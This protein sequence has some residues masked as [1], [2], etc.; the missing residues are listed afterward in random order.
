VGWLRDLVLSSPNRVGGFDHLA[1]LCLASAD[2]P[3]NVRLGHRSLGAILGKLDRDESLDWLANRPGVQAAIAGALG[4]ERAVVQDAT[5]GGRLG[6]PNRLVALDA[7]PFARGLDLLE[8]D[9]FPG[10]PPEVF[11]SGGY[12]RLVW[13]CPSGGGRSLVGRWLRARGLATI[14]RR[15]NLKVGGPSSERRPLFLEL[16]SAEGLELSKLNPGICVTVPEDGDGGRIAERLAAEAEARAGSGAG[17]VRIVRSVPIDSLLRPLVEWAR[18]RLSSA[19]TW[20]T[21]AMVSA[22]EGAVSRGVARS[23]GD[24]LGLVGLAD[25]VGLGVFTGRSLSRLGAEWIRRRAS[26]RLERD[27]PITA[28][29]KNHGYEALV[30][31]VRRIATEDDDAISD[32]RTL[33][34]WARLL[35][36]DMKRGADLEWLKTALTRAEPS[37]RA[38]D[39]ERITAELP[40]EAF[41]ILRA[42]EALGVL[43]RTEDGASALRPHWLVRVA[44]SDAIESVVSGAAFDW[45]EAL[46]SPVLG[47]ATL[48]GLFERASSH[49]LAIDEIDPEP[50]PDPAGSASIEGAVRA[51]G[52]ARLMTRGAGDTS[53]AL[54]DEQLRLAVDLGDG[55]RP[56]WERH[57]PEGGLGA[58]LLSNGAWHLAL[59]ALGELLPAGVGRQHPLLRPWQERAVPARFHVVLDSVLAALERRDAPEGIHGPA[60]ALVGRLRGVL[61]PLGEGG[62]PHRLERA[63]I[64]AD[65]VA[66]GVLS[67]ASFAALGGDRVGI[68][69]LSEL[70]KERG[71]ATRELAEVV[72]RAF[73]EGTVSAEEA[74]VLVEPGLAE[75][76]MPHAPVGVLLKLGPELVATVKLG[77]EQW[78]PLLRAGLAVTEAIAREVPRTALE[79]AVDGAVGNGLAVLWDRFPSLLGEMT[80]VALAGTDARSSARLRALLAGAPAKATGELAVSVDNVDALLRA[81]GATLMALREH[82]HAQLVGHLGAPTKQFHETYA[83]FDELERRCAKVSMR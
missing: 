27:A 69:G 9:L 46:L 73:E 33:E 68:R 49:K 20:E 71:L 15:R 7:L 10:I 72:F 56:R 23:A 25:S 48:E 61:G 76:L 36:A 17:T 30:A 54:W 83:L 35:P 55:P 64:V 3:A 16:G 50:A 40:P 42:F 53:E 31:L 11:H 63:A 22:I 65:E 24:V 6:E 80:R 39:L 19:S 21:Y 2:W 62:T 41:R 5:R 45:G 8:E 43:E 14:E 28:W 34:E 26:E 12:Q 67:F 77:E 37:L 81:P 66:L 59:L 38:A 79:L 51:L 60:V 57:P 58:F 13:V 1:K 70:V 4:T 78:P 82:L 44:L 32:A 29:M 74:R 52:I 75:L 47:P 18:A